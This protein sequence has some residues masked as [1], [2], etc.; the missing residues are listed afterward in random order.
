M[1]TQSQH[2]AQRADQAEAPAVSR[3]QRWAG[4]IITVLAS[5]FLLFDG[6]IHLLMP[7][8]VVEAFGRLGYP[9]NL[10]VPL[11][12]IAL[13]CVAFYVVPRTSVL[14]AILLTG[15]LGGAVATNLRV[16]DPLFET[17]FPAL[18]GVL[19]WLGIFLREDRLRA[20]L[21][22]RSQDHKSNEKEN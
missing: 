19:V 14:G 20:L 16:G 2:F 9:I 8:P 11:G 1:A 5:L 22:L 10:S 17:I 12:I 4:G 18:F 13:T 6:V 15:Y 3:S 21:P 7:A